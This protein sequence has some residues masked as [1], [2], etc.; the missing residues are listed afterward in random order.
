MTAWHD[1]NVNGTNITKGAVLYCNLD[2][3]KPG[4]AKASMEV[5]KIGAH[6]FFVPH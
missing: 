6:T 2:V 5:A 1:A 3:V 4:W